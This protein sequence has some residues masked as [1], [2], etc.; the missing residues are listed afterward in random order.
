MFGPL[1]P[2]FTHFSPFPI[3]SLTLTGHNTVLAAKSSSSPRAVGR[4]GL[5][6]AVPQQSGGGLALGPQPAGTKSFQ[7]LH[8]P[9]QVLG[10]GGGR[11]VVADTEL[12]AWVRTSTPAPSYSPH[13]FVTLGLCFRPARVLH[14]TPISSPSLKRF[15]G[16]WC[17]FLQL[18]PHPP[19]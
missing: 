11:V 8:T 2:G 17:A 16:L 19:P 5:W 6:T 18:L 10:R 1:S 14:A 9:L 7:E 13:P 15:C 3:H 4:S 12:W